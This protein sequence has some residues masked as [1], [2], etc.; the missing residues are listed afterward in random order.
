M[1]DIKSIAGRIVKLSHL[2]AIALAHILAQEYE[3]KPKECLKEELPKDV[4]KIFEMKDAANVDLAE[5]EKT[6][7]QEQKRKMYVPRKVGKPCKKKF[8][9]HK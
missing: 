6:L 5:V 9:R 3:I 1:A 2:E 7:K 4:S 8:S